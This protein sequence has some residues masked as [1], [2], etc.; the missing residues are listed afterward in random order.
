M[1]C[2]RLSNWCGSS[3]CVISN[4][5]AIKEHLYD[6]YHVNYRHDFDFA[7]E[8]DNIPCLID[9]IDNYKQNSIEYP[10]EFLDPLLY[11]VIKDPVKIGRAHV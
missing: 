7:E 4:N 9:I 1:V 10:E 5:D 3:L 6:I 2:H 8:L 11:T